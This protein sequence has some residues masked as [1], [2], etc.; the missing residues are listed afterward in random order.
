MIDPNLEEVM[1]EVARLRGIGTQLSECH[2][3]AA[4][5]VRQI[6]D[7]V[8]ELIDLVLDEPSNFVGEMPWWEDWKPA[9]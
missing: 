6:I 1:K 8:D 2:H 4:P 7:I 5:L 3:R 9:K